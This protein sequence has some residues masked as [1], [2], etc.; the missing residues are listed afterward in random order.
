VV[1]AGL[2][3]KLR[4]DVAN[5]FDQVYRLRDGTGIGISASQYGPRRGL[6]AGAALLF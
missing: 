3:V 6:Y 2:A 5:L 4:L 1:S